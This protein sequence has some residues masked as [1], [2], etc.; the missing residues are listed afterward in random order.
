MCVCVCGLTILLLIKWYQT[1][2]WNDTSWHSHSQSEDCEHVVL[3]V[4]WLYKTTLTRDL[5]DLL[6]GIILGVFLETCYFMVINIISHDIYSVSTR[7]LKKKKCILKLCIK[8]HK[9]QSSLQK[10]I[11][12]NSSIILRIG[13][14]F[15]FL[16]N[17]L[18]RKSQNI[19][20][21]ILSDP[22]Y[23][24]YF[25]HQIYNFAIHIYI[26]LSS[27]GMSD[28]IHPKVDDYCKF[29]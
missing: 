15:I 3:A 5:F 27:L 12:W 14:E 25:S 18:I 11:I 28:F 29:N 17:T 20:I 4:I 13:V 7:R 22:L 23:I 16:L 1:S 10:A 6:R 21:I 9:I 8:L 19:H 24:Y 2:D 26:I